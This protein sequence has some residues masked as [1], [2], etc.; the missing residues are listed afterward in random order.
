MSFHSLNLKKVYLTN[1][2]YEKVLSDLS[3]GERSKNVKDLIELKFVVPQG[4]NEEK[5]FDAVASSLL[6]KKPQ[7][8]LA[9][10]L[11]TDFCNFRCG[12]C[13]I[14]NNLKRPSSA[15]S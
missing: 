11:V 13:F 3:K 9:Y 5:V 12:Y 7:S 10:I 4:F 1:K 6:R 14:E 2:K 15:M 8:S